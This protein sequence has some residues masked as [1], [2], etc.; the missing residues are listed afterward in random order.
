MKTL[1]LTTY[2]HAQIIAKTA[3]RT[4]CM[5]SG[6]TGMA[7][8]L[9]ASINGRDRATMAAYQAVSNGI[10]DID[11]GMISDAW[12]LVQE[13]ALAIIEHS[14]D[15]VDHNAPYAI[16]DNVRKAAYKAV[17]NYVYRQAR[18][19]ALRNIYIED[20]AHN[21][22]GECVDANYI[23][24]TRYFDV[25]D[26]EDWC[27][28]QD[29][30]DTLGGHLSDYQIIILHKRLQG[31]SITKIAEQMHVSVAAISRQLS[32]MRSV[33]AKLYPD[34]IRLIMQPPRAKDDHNL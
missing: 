28:Y 2:Q 12:D 19:H 32:K 9:R 14:S 1:Q 25:S 11:L 13:A 22:A 34:A 20:M 4:M 27:I 18:R 7:Y 5:A 30:L 15:D 29:M 8:K 24:V 31:L 10:A 23:R 26:Y 3:L 17:H 33:A 16:D 6:N 21:D